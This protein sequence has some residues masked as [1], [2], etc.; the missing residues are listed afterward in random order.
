MTKSCGLFCKSIARVKFLALDLNVIS[1]Y[2][3]IIVAYN[4]IFQFYALEV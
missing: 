4:F 3:P 1:E 2:P